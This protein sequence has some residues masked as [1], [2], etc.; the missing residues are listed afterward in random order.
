MDWHQYW[1]LLESRIAQVATTWGVR[2]VSAI[3]LAIIGWIIAGW[4]G[5]RTRALAQRST[6]VDRTLVSVLAKIARVSVL[7]IVFIAVLD[8]LGVDTASFLAFLGA[9]GLAVGLALKDTASD[10][11]GGL[12]LLVLRPF[13]VGDAVMIGTT[14]GTVEEIG[15]FQ[16]SLTTFE[17]VPVVVPNSRV[18]TSEIQNFT[19]AEKRRIDLTIGVSYTADLDRVREI[20]RSVVTSDARVLADPA[21]LVDV[22]NLGESSVDLLVRV[23]VAASVYTDTKLA[24]GRTIKQRLDAEGVEIPFPQRVVHTRPDQRA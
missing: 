24:L 1:M 16:T 15:V 20:L 19:R 17:G 7:V 5:R 21:P 18:R 6:H 3:A 8:N 10:V 2:L 11:A 22:T 23:W 13:S 12:V 9:A 14:G 4:I